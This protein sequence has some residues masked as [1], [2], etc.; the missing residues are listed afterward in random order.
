[1]LSFY[2]FFEITLHEKLKKLGQKSSKLMDKKIRKRWPVWKC[3]VFHG[4][5]PQRR[6]A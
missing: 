4:H 1:M 3:P 2:S 6:S 5:M